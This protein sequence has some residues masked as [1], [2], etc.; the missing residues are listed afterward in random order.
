MTKHSDHAPQVF[1]SYSLAD[2][3]AARDV[4][5][6]LRAAD[7]EVYDA[8]ARPRP[9]SDWEDQ[10]RLALEACNAVV[11]VLGRIGDRQQVPANILFEIGAA[12]Q[13]GKPIYVLLRDPADRLPFR[14]SGLTVLPLNNVDAIARQLRAA[15]V[16]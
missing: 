10:L 1:L 12:S 9:G 7:I 11:I 8:L 14:V 3:E 13:A 4:L 2:A 15:A 6:R 16:A 5:R